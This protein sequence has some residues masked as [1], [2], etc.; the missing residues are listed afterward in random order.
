[1]TLVKNPEK[2]KKEKTDANITEERKEE[3]ERCSIY[4]S[5]KWERETAS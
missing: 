3:M 4:M 2:N 5:I 1:M